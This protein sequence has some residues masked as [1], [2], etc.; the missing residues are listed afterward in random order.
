MM[1]EGNFHQ[2]V[3][4]FKGRT[5]EKSSRCL[6]FEYGNSD[7]NF[8]TRTLF[9]SPFHQQYFDRNA[10]HVSSV[11]SSSSELIL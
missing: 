4:S 1:K 11:A 6:K 9:N 3:F 5:V 8:Q 2:C 10:S 7:S